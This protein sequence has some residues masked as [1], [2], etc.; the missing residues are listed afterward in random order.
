M[1]IRYLDGIIPYLCYETAPWSDCLKVIH[2][3][4][5]VIYGTSRAAD[6]RLQVR[7]AHKTLRAVRVK[8]QSVSLLRLEFI[9]KYK[10]TD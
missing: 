10:V 4:R 8:R 7:T 9:V 2:S 6:D 1:H 3:A 5:C